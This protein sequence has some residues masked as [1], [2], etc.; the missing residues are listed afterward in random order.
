MLGAVDEIVD[1]VQGVGSFDTG[2]MWSPNN[3]Q[4]ALVAGNNLQIYN[5]FG[6]ATTADSAS[7]AAAAAAT[8]TAGSSSMASNL[9]NLTGTNFSIFEQFNFIK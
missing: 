9:A 6:T 1:E 2:F 5:F 4:L 7:R 8:S 3:E